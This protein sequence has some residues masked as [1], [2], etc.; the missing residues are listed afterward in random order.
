MIT[1]TDPI[2]HI[3]VS[4]I[5][6]LWFFGCDEM[7]AK[8]TGP[9]STSNE[10]SSKEEERDRPTAPEF[11]LKDLSGNEVSLK[12]LKG[13]IVLLDFWATWCPPCRRSIPE[14]VAIQG[15]YKDQG[16]VILGVSTDDPRKTGDKSLLAFKNQYR[17][18][19]SILR[20]DYDVTMSYFGTTQMAIPSL[21]VIDREGG[22][23]AKIVG[24]QP[25]V[26]EKKLKKLL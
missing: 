2:A 20:A 22:V 24:Y 15:K 6:C 5:L 16:L 3:F 18:N 11:T 19:Y 13:Q 8:P 9:N 26:V 25:G 17:I 14:L 21:F 10:L 4:L 23:V 1:K 7:Q 12:E